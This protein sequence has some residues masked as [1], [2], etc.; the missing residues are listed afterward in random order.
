[1]CAVP[2]GSW[3]GR[4]PSLG[5]DLTA[6]GATNG[7]TAAGGRSCCLC[8][9][10]TIAGLGAFHRGE[11]VPEDVDGRVEMPAVQVT[12]PAVRAAPA[13]ENR[14]HRFGL[15]DGERRAGLDG[16]VHA[17]VFAELVPRTRQLFHGI[18]WG[19]VF[20]SDYLPSVDYFAIAMN[21]A[22][23]AV[24]RCRS[25]SRLTRRFSGCQI[26]ETHRIQATQSGVQNLRHT[27]I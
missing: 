14:G 7:A 25:V 12:T 18:E 24:P 23:L 20:S 3:G 13:L 6:R 8:S 22:T 2:S 4:R 10:R 15:H 19:H 9:R 1:M 17:A 27:W 21:S 16:H 5:G 11:L 26:G